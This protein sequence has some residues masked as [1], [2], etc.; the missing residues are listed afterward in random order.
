LWRRRLFRQARR[1]NAARAERAYCQASIAT[2]TRLT[3]LGAGVLAAE[4]LVAF[5]QEAFSRD[6]KN[7]NEFNMFSLGGW[8][9]P[10]RARNRLIGDSDDDPFRNT[11]PFPLRPDRRARMLVA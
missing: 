5:C 7:S 10:F 1:E 3:G 2:K 11:R 6:A 8:H 4:G 9:T